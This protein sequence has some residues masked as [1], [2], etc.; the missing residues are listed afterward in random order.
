E[1]QSSEALGLTIEYTD[2][3][4]K[5]PRRETM[6][7]Q[8]ANGLTTRMATK[9]D[10]SEYPDETFGM[11]QVRG[12]CAVTGVVFEDLETTEGQVEFKSG[13]QNVKVFADLAGKTLTIGT[14]A[15]MQDKYGEE[16]TEQTVG[17]VIWVGRSED[18][19]EG[20]VFPWGRQADV[21]KFL[22]IIA[23]EPIK[24]ARE[25]SK[26]AAAAA[27]TA[28]SAAAGAAFGAFGGTA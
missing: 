11:K 15:T 24:D 22:A 6:W 12:I 10:G 5:Y 25:L 9:R 23:K 26:P 19:K 8:G 16:T 7:F 1:S 3:K 2:G 14:Q 20:V 27:T 17:N 18:D 21:A 28:G 4:W 13:I